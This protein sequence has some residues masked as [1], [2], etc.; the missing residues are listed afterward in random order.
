M[1]AWSMLPQ[2]QPITPPS[3]PPK[4]DKTLKH[5]LNMKPKDG[6]EQCWQGGGIKL[7][8]ENNTGMELQIS[9]RPKQP[10]TAVMVT[11]SVTAPDAPAGAPPQ[12]DNS[13]PHIGK[14]AEEDIKALV[15]SHVT[16]RM[17][18]VEF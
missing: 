2:G 12:R 15:D 1:S 3:L 17:N 8:I 6:K 10:G 4:D 18:Q 11:Q 5:Q 7:W 13:E 9:I 16:Q 14:P